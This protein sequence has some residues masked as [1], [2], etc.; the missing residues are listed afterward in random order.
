M[1]LQTGSKWQLLFNNV[2]L[3]LI[4]EAGRQELPPPPI[5][6]SHCSATTTCAC[7]SKAERSKW[8]PEV[9][10]M[11]PLTV[12]NSAASALLSTAPTAPIV[13]N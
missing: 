1:S 10:C 5:A 7:L 6:C 11:N 9:V 2:L 12:M 3:M 13:T 8:R 4:Q